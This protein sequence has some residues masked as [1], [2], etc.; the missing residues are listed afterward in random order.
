MKY[1]WCRKLKRG[2]I[3]I[4]RTYVLRVLLYIGMLYERMVFDNVCLILKL[5]EEINVVMIACVFI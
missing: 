4:R 1:R 3:I 5:Y 2:S